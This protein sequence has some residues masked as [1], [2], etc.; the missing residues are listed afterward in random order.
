VGWLGLHALLRLR[1][2]R[3][4]AA[5]LAA[6]AALGLLAAGFLVADVLGFALFWHS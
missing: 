6:L 5:A 2:G 3:W 4:L 1:K